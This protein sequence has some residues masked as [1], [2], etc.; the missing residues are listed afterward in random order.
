MMK[1]ICRLQVKCSL[2]C[3]YIENPLFILCVSFI[4]LFVISALIVL[5][6]I[7]YFVVSCQPP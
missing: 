5:V 7:F 3:S 2:L 4:Y 6:E 1:S